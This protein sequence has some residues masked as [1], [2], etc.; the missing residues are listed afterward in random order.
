MPIM[1]ELDINGIPASLECILSAFF[2]KL[3]EKRALPW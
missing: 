3:E 2:Y 1:D